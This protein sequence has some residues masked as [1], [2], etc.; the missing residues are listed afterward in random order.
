MRLLCSCLL[1][2]VALSADSLELTTGERIEGS[3]VR[4]AEKVVVI[5][6]GGQE[7]EMPLGKVRAIYLGAAPGPTKSNAPSAYQE[8]LEQL[9][10]LQSVTTSG[11]SYREYAPRV[12]DA[13]I[14]VDRFLASA[15]VGDEKIRSLIS[16]SIRY[17]EIAAKSWNLTVTNGFDLG[18]DLLLF[19]DTSLRECPGYAEILDDRIN[20]GRVS[21]RM[22]G[23]FHLPMLFECGSQPLIE[24][25]KLERPTDAIADSPAPIAPAVGSLSVLPAP[26]STPTAPTIVKPAPKP[27]ATNKP[28][29]IGLE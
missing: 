18:Y 16:R 9:R 11:V 27:D 3:F 23:A 5:S 24:I 6:V 26:T 13:R 29:I 17:Y 4:A 19:A 21:A 8:A 28:R 22:L 2:M 15:P 7:I 25:A 10:S 20:H 1:S 14:K 12:L